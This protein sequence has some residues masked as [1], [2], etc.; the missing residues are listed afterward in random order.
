MGGCS[1]VVDTYGGSVPILHCGYGHEQR[2]P[3]VRECSRRAVDGHGV[4]GQCLQVE[5]HLREVVDFRH[6]GDVRVAVDGVAGEVHDREVKVVVRH[7]HGVRALLGVGCRQ[8]D[9]GGDEEDGVF[10]IILSFILV[11]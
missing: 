1:V 6:H 7:M 3:D 9:E 4:G 2:L 5:A 11:C 10:H 8:G